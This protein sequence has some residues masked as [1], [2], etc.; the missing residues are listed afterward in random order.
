M[1]STTKV[2]GT[3]L[4]LAA[5]GLL[6]SATAQAASHAEAGK[7]HCIGANECKGKSACKTADNACGGKNACKGKGFTMATKAEC[8]KAKG[9]FEAPKAEA[10]K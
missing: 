2:T 8:E 3:L 9:K 10:K 5:A 6:M 7:G 4:A 1:K